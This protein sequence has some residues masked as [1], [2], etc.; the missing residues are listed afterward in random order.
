MF[1]TELHQNYFIRMEN[2]NIEFRAND[3]LITIFII[4]YDLNGK[5]KHDGD[6]IIVKDN[7][8]SEKD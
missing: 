3:G 4:Q 5:Y 8:F 2:T 7:V 6:S 1:H